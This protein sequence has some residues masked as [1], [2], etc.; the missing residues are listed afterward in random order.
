MAADGFQNYPFEGDPD[1][2]AEDAYA[3]LQTLIPG[4]VPHEGAFAT[5]LIAAGARMAA[6][7]VVVAQDT[8]PGIFRRF[9][10]KLAGL[11]P[12]QD[13]QATVASTWTVTDTLGYT[14][15]A[16]TVVGLRAPGG[17]DLVYFEVTDDVD[18]PAGESTTAAGAVT[19]QAQQ[20]GIQGNG[21]GGAG[22]PATPATIDPRVAT[23]TTTGLS[24]GG[25]DAETDDAYEDRL[26]RDLSLRSILAIRAIDFATLAQDVDEVH[27]A[28]AL[29]RYVPPFNEIQQVVVG[30]TGGTFT[31]TFSGQTTTAIA[32]NATAATILAALE[33]LSNINP[34][35]IVV[36]GGPAA[37][38]PVVVEF[39]GQYL[40]T[41]VPQMTASGTGLT[42]T[43]AAVTVTTTRSASNEQTAVDGAVTVAL[44]G[45]TGDPVSAAASATVKAKLDAARLPNLN[46]YV[47]DPTYTTVDVTFTATSYPG[48]DPADVQAR[49]RQA[50]IDYLSPVGWGSPAGGE[51]PQWLAQTQVEAYELSEAINRVDGVWRATSIMVALAGQTPAEGA[52]INLGGVNKPAVLPRPGTITGTVTAG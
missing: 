2:I 25:Q 24:S 45:F 37:S 3:Y 20:P 32:Y 38:S 15:A 40:A 13:A 9:G 52:N 47:I 8:P 12:N 1:A 27:S 19:L 43:G 34:G 10:A 39:R 28:L 30:A 17:A 26:R 5:R 22:A 48:W 31:L 14:V 36:T 16:G 35:D 11:P 23:V 41:D 33:A 50:V 18:I 46:L 6:E 4:W 49:A 21:V 29:N 44:R 7:L 42:G 51:Q